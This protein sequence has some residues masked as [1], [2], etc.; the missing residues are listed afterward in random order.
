MENDVLSRVYYNPER[1]GSFSGV[2]ALSRAAGTSEK[3]ARDWLS[4]QLTYTLH[5]GVRQRFTTRPY[6]TNKMDSQW[7][8]DLVEMIPYAN[9]NR[10]YKYLLTVID[11]FSRYAWARPIKSKRP[12]NVIRAFES[13]FQQE[14]RKCKVLQTDQG[15]EF[16]NREFQ[17]FLNVH[18]VKFFTVKS[19]F[20][21]ALVERLNRTIKTRMWRYFTH[22]GQYR[23]LEV[24]PKLIYSYNAS[25]HRVIGIAPQDVNVENEID[26]WSKQQ[27]RYPQ[28]V[29]SSAL[30]DKHPV[31][32]VGDHV[33]ISKYKSIFDK[34][35]LPNW[36]EEVFTISRVIKT[37]K[38]RRKYSGPTQYKIRDERGEEIEG[39]F[40]GTEL[41]KIV[42]PERFRVERVIRRRMVRGRPQYLVQWMGYGP[43][44]NSWVDEVEDM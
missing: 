25:V 21:A 33:R 28:K 37:P 23:W 10:G 32:Q 3:V 30:R 31:F 11:I 44:F 1:A 13:I 17:H 43:E 34:G 39:S 36:T 40:Y 12:R 4:K 20:K 42:P 5:K 7:Q 18:D 19:L 41:Q 8:A 29:G 14:G 2:R 24:L 6:R 35:Y 15:K 16:E 26:L 22:T 38:I 9:V 27:Q